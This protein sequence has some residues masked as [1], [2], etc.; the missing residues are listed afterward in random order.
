VSK[1]P[2]EAERQW[3]RE[4]AQRR[5]NVMFG[6]EPA[7]RLSKRERE[8]WQRVHR[9][10]QKHRRWIEAEIARREKLGQSTEQIA[11]ELD[12]W[13]PPEDP[14]AEFFTKRLNKVRLDDFDRK[15][16]QA[17][18]DLV[19]SDVPLNSFWRRLIA[20]EL[21]HLYFPKESD[22]KGKQRAELWAARSLQDHLQNAQGMSATEAEAEVAKTIGIE[23]D[24]L[25]KRR[26]R[27]HS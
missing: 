18:V 2:D 6:L 26:Q 10:E 11:H 12:L 7:R 24:V 13:I 22:K 21:Q 27:Q 14:A 4:Q 20:G 17:L 8:E 25:R 16:Q 1:K 19:A 5:F 3:R 23:V 15:S 9:L